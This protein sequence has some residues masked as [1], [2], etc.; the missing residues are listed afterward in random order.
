MTGHDSSYI[1]KVYDTHVCMYCMHVGPRR[2]DDDDDDDVAGDDVRSS[3]DLGPT[4]GG[5]VDRS[6][7]S[8]DRSTTAEGRE[9]GNEG[10]FGV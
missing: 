1:V 6:R 4:V 5:T 10:R 9:R 8:I 2:M 3:I 7:R